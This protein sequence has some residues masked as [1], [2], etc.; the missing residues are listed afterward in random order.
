VEIEYRRAEF[1]Y[2]RLPELAADLVGHKADVIVTNGGTP[3]A[4]AA[5]NATSR[6]PIVFNDVADPV[7][8]GLVANLARPGGNLTPPGQQSPS[9]PSSPGAFLAPRVQVGYVACART[10]VCG[11]RSGR[12]LP[13][14]VCPLGH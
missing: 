1:Q 14:H 13:G 3:P 12:A 4:L 7:G 10:R 6:I 9:V 11:T 8:F 5:K 2:D